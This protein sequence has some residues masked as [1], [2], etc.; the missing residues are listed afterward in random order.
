MERNE[1]N[2]FIE[3]LLSKSPI[4][5]NIQTVGKYDFPQLSQ[6][7][8]LPELPVYPFNYLKSTVAKGR[9]WYHCFTS[10]K[11]FH[12]LYHSFDEYLPFLQQTKGIISA[13]FCLYRDY[14]EEILIE[15]CRANRLIDYALQQAGIPMIPTAGFAGETSW[16][17]CFD[18]LPTNST[19]AVTTNTLGNDPE[20][21]RL[22]VGGI[23]VIVE[24]LQPTA[25]IVCGK[26]PEW[27]TEKFPKINVVQIPN[28]SMMWQE[29][30]RRK[31]LNGRL[32]RSKR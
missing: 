27:I 9:Y 30:E 10:E 1:F 25:I 8:Y 17:W 22:F 24:K 19:V 16:E 3:H 6:L 14:P 11:Y 18:G 32:R 28:Y 20:A 15:N 23:N 5:G 12:R 7:N 13:D 2:Y 21:K 31:K 4:E 29:R 26:C